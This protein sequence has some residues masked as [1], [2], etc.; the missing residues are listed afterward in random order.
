MA[1]ADKIVVFGEERC[2]L[3]AK[4]FNYAK[5]DASL[6]FVSIYLQN[7]SVFQV[8]RK[9]YEELVEKIGTSTKSKSITDR[10]NEIAELKDQC[11]S[12]DCDNRNLERELSSIRT[13]HDDLKRKQT[14]HE[15]EKEVHKRREDEITE[16]QRMIRSLNEVTRLSDDKKYLDRLLYD[17]KKK[18]EELLKEKNSVPK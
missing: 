6:E 14:E 5:P 11:E 12:L 15:R 1:E 3:N 9:E 13:Q 10:E 16:L 17:V 7:G 2:M 18:N 4:N 8:S